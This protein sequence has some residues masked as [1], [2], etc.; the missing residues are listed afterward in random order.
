MIMDKEKDNSS[1][2]KPNDHLANRTDLPCLG[3]N[4]DWYYGLRL[5]CC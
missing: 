3:Q 2:F 5:C 4:R 1:T